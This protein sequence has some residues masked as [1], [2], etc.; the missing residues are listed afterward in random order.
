MLWSRFDIASSFGEFARR[1][2]PRLGL[3]GAT[4]VNHPKLPGENHRHLNG[5]GM[6][7]IA[8]P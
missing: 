1:D 4:S 3:D 6:T 8:V 7:L 5:C 2:H